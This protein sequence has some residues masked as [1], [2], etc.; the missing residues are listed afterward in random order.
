M[1]SI[2]KEVHHQVDQVINQGRNQVSSLVDYHVWC[3][4]A[5]H[6]R[7]QV[8]DEVWNQVQFQVWDQP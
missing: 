1:K 3:Q 2:S 4:V 5:D 6:I 7:D 8:E